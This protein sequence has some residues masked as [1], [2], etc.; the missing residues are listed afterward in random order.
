MRFLNGFSINQDN[1][2]RQLP[3]KFSNLLTNMNDK[4]LL[5]D[6]ITKINA[7]LIKLTMDQSSV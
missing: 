3:D 6:V 4:N 7:N 1:I 2:I 5:K